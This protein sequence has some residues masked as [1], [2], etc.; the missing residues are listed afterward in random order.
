MGTGSESCF[1]RVRALSGPTDTPPQGCPASAAVIQAELTGPSAVAVGGLWWPLS[2][3]Q[4]SSGCGLASPWRPAGAGNTTQ[5][6]G[7]GGVTD[8][9]QETRWWGGDGAG[10]CSSCPPSLDV[11]CGFSGDALSGGTPRWAFLRS[12][13]QLS[14]AG[15]VCARPASLPGS[16]FALPFV[17]LGLHPQ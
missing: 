4:G 16:P 15:L 11:S 17:G 13:G 8:G 10:R 5:K 7:V 3:T 9:G 1:C 12:C 2:Q 14:E 6:G